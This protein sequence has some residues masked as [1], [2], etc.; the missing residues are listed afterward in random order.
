V[1]L[2]SPELYGHE[3]T[4]FSSSVKEEW[5]D[6]VTLPVED[7]LHGLI[8]L[9]NELVRNFPDPSTGI[10]RTRYLS[11]DELVCWGNVDIVIFA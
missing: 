10:T 2:F 11:T 9:V 4:F 3:I 1:S 5:K 6:R 7:Y 8:S